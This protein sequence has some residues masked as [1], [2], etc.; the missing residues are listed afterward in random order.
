MQ[1]LLTLAYCWATEQ[2]IAQEKIN[3]FHRL[4]QRE[5]IIGETHSLS[6]IYGV[7]VIMALIMKNINQNTEW[8]RRL[9][10][11]AVDAPRRPLIGLQSAGFPTNWDRQDIWHS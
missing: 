2:I 3:S 7:F 8:Y 6:Q 9:V 10:H 4:Y 11:L 5:L 1:V